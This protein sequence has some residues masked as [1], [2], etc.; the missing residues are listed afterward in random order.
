M[1]ASSSAP[2][3]GYVTVPVRLDAVTWWKIAGEA[4]DDLTVAEVIAIRE[5]DRAAGRLPAAD[6]TQAGT[7][8]ERVRELLEEGYT[9]AAI[10]A[11]LGCSVS[12]VGHHRRE[13]IA[14][15]DSGSPTRSKQ[16]QEV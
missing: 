16:N 15:A 11:E 10:A 5:T 12:N 6:P 1:P 2:R 13:L 8:R 14:L 3:G 9:P 4:G 7:T